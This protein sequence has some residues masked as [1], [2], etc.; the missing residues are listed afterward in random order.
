MDPNPCAA[1]KTSVESG[2]R[3]SAP[4]AATAPQ[5]SIGQITLAAFLGALLAA[6]WL[7]AANFKAIGQ[8]IKAHRILWWGAVM[9]ACL[10]DDPG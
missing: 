1:P 10:F 7:G 5:Y 6:V 4:T 9:N 3:D 2:L 8:P